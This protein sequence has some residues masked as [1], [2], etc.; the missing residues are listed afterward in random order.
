MRC[1]SA[2]SPFRPSLCRADLYFP[3]ISR[4][5]RDRAS[6]PAARI[7]RDCVACFFRDISSLP[8]FLS[9]SFS[10]QEILL[11]R[12]KYNKRSQPSRVY[13]RMK[14]LGG[15]I[16]GGVLQTSNRR[17]YRNSE[18]MEE[19]S[20]PLSRL[21]FFRRI[22]DL[23][24]ARLLSP[25]SPFVSARFVFFLV[26][27]GDATPGYARFDSKMNVI[28]RGRSNEGKGGLLYFRR[29]R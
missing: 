17:A 18:R 23:F 15:G 20:P 9:F 14:L 7:L 25:V 29:S 3:E 13:Y 10:L 2:S 27:I 5:F 21:V 16:E 28:V 8:L 22:E 1:S 24:V 4:D 19:R 6:S 12:E 11:Q 26:V